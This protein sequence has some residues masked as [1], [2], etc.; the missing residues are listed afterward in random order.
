MADPT[1][2]MANPMGLGCFI[3]GLSDGFLW[4]L[5]LLDFELSFQM[6]W[7]DFLLILG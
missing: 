5:V 3:V 4:I 6:F 1:A 2:A 7:F